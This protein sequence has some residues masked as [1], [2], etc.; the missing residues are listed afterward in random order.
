M[1]VLSE[2]NL[3]IIFMQHHQLKIF[4]MILMFKALKFDLKHTQNN[5]LS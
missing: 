2:K 5:M 3:Q 4:E 1:K